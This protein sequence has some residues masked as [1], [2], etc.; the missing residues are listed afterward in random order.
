MSTS[1]TLNT[2]PSQDKP[3]PEWLSR[4]VIR[5]VA[6]EDLPSLEWEGEYS[7]YR[8]N[9]S[10]AYK[11][12]KTGRAVMWVLELPGSGLIGQVFVQLDMQDKSCANGRSR[13]YIHS[14]RVR[15][16]M[17]GH[18][19]GT[20]LMDH[21]EQDLAQRGFREI[22]LN[23]AEENEGAMRL[24]KRLGYKIAKRIPGR[25]SYYDEKGILRHVSE[26]GFRLKKSLKR[27]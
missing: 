20:W 24:Y 17:R 11:R 2:G 15:P 25:W 8:R 6:E 10:D 16:A 18:G 23:V 9:Y 22:T 4:V 13:A 1:Q 7:R 12:T 5:H 3:S 21:T 26:P 14:F 19:L 27:K